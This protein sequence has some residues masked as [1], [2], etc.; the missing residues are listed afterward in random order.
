MKHLLFSIILT[1]L[2]YSVGFSQDQIKDKG[3]QTFNKNVNDTTKRE[4]FLVRKTD[5]N[6]LYGF[7]LS[8]DG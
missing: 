6:E 1:M 5:G 7:I 3:T 2:S 4:L 8:D